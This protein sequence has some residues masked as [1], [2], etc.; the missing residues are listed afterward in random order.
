[1]KS[2]ARDKECFTSINWP[3]TADRFKSHGLEVCDK[4]TTTGWWDGQDH[5]HYGRFIGQLAPAPPPQ[6]NINCLLVGCTWSADTLSVAQHFFCGSSSVISYPNTEAQRQDWDRLNARY[7]HVGRL[8]SG[9]PEQAAHVHPGEDL[10][11]PQTAAAGSW[12]SYLAAQVSKHSVP[13]DKAGTSS[14]FMT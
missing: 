7:S 5:N 6:T 12:P 10:A 4:S 11:S 8:G 14:P 2:P 13:G 1:M 3:N 9:W